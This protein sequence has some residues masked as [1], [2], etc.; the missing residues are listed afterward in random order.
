MQMRLE[1]FYLQYLKQLEILNQKINLSEI[2]DH[3]SLIIDHCHWSLITDHWSLIA[4]H[5]SL[6]TDLS[7]QGNQASQSLPRCDGC[8][9]CVSARWKAASPTKFHKS[10]LLPP[11]LLMSS[12]SDTPEYFSTPRLPTWRNQPNLATVS[13]RW[14]QYQQVAPAYG[15][16]IFDSFRSLP[17]VRQQ[18]VL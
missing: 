7:S 2:G 10:H 1:K 16:S 17:V 11:S 13:S 12:S 15:A 3:W 6:I 5:W 4:D 18:H 8:L 14:L 9:R